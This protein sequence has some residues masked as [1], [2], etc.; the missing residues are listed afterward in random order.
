MG[1]E[2]WENPSKPVP[3]EDEEGYR[4]ADQRG[5]Q[6]YLEVSERSERA[7]RKTRLFCLFRVFALL[8]TADG[9]FRSVPEQPPCTK[10][11]RCPGQTRQ[12]C[13]ILRF[14]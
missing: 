7:L 12:P 13:P 6:E 14:F 5:V 11:K 9:V 4:R 2:H 8:L 3:R 10:T 1:R